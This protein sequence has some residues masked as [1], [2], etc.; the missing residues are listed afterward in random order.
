MKE[1]THDRAL[2]LIAR[3]LGQFFRAIIVAAYAAVGVLVVI[4]YDGVRDDL[5]RAV[6]GVSTVFALRLL[7][8]FVPR[9]TDV[10][11]NPGHGT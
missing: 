3:G 9:P 10:N 6:F 4:G 5:W 2:D 11:G 8:S 7:E 1:K